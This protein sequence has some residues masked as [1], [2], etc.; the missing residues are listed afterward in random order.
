MYTE[1][2]EVSS[3]DVDPNGIIRPSSVLRYMQEA[4]NHQMRDEKPSYMDLFNEGKAFLLSRIAVH[5]FEPLHQYDHIDVVNWPADG[6][7]ATFYRCY[8]IECNG[9]PIAQGLGIWALVDTHTHRL[10]RVGEVS[11]PN[12]TTGDLVQVEGLRFRLP[13]ELERVGTHTV[14][15]HETDCNRHLN[16]TNYPDLLLDVL[17]ERDTHY[18]SDFSIHFIA[19]APLGEELTF[20]R[21]PA[22]ATAAGLCRYFRTERADGSANIEAMVHLSPL[23]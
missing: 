16:N 1:H 19:E 5:T 13:E 8:R 14:C 3:H 9:H 2:F 23:T 21:S 6:R 12:Y 22:I 15:Y 11:F 20:Y 17:P 4:A 10:Y 18:I 7:G